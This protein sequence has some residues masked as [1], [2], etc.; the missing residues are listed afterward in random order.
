MNRALLYDHI[1]RAGD[2]YGD[3]VLC[4]AVLAVGAFRRGR[5]FVYLNA[6]GVR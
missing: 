6:Y 2:L 5:T 1:A 3:T 4:R